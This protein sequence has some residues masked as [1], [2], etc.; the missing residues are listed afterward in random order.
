MS[1]E[2]E[3]HLISQ[4][5]GG[6]VTEEA[7]TRASQL[8]SAMTAMD[9]AFEKAMQAIAS[10]RA[11][12]GTPEH[13]LGN[14][15]T[16]HGEIAEQVEV[17]VR[18]A[19]DYLVGHAPTAT[20]EGVGRTAP[21]DYLIDG[22]MVQSK[23]INGARNTLDNVL[24][25]YREN[26]SFQTPDPYYHI[27]RDQFAELNRLLHGDVPQGMSAHSAGALLL[28]IREIEAFT[29]RHFGDVVRPSL[30]TYGEVQ[31]GRIHDTMEQHEAELEDA[32]DVQREEAR[33]ASAPTLEGVAGA[34]AKGAVV[35]AGVRLT[36]V[37]YQKVRGGKN[38]LKGQFG[39]DDWKDVGICAATGGA[40]GGVAAGVI[41]ALTNYSDLSAPFAGAFV[42][43]AMAVGSLA[44]SY[45]AGEIAF[46]EFVE[47][48]QLACSEAAIVGIATAVGQAAIPVPALGALVG[49]VAGRLLVAQVRTWATG[50]AERVLKDLE[51]RV[52]ACMAALQDAERRAVEQALEALDRLGDLTVVA[53]DLQKNSELLL[54]ASVA[55]AEAHGVDSGRILRSSGDVDR[56]ML[57]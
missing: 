33:A 50:E 23:F 39:L 7:G 17:G 52:S 40:Q 14:S 6:F 29:G 45:S 10:V 27:P 55:L 13:I 12:I 49:A 47:L 21:H 4:L 18:R 35:G 20:F 38:P 54:Q 41:F 19:W 11:F 36:A 32:D 42:S 2:P 9:V 57:A 25:H 28:K 34:A 24:S 15:Q 43:S 8:A 3:D 26:P 30:S 51:E 46:D 53:F 31:Q 16:K 44:R 5:A 56:Y 48:G 1:T 37:T 22:T